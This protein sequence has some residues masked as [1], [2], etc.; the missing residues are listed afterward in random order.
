MV[1]ACLPTLRP[2]LF[3]V[4]IPKLSSTAGFLSR[5]TPTRSRSSSRSASGAAVED[6]QAGL[7]DNACEMAVTGKDEEEGC[8]SP[9]TVK[10]E[11]RN[12]M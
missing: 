6:S 4:L 11:F 2:L 9:A 8:S 3:R 7:A 10:Q 1:T 5:K 12:A